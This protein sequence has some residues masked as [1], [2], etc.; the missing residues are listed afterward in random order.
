M[1]PPVA[2]N[3]ANSLCLLFASHLFCHTNF[4]TGNAVVTSSRILV[5]Q[6]FIMVSNYEYI[7][8]FRFCLHASIF[9]ELRTTG[10]LSTVPSDIGLKETIPYETTVAPGVLV[11]YHQH[12]FC[13]RID[14][15]IDG[16]T[17]SLAI[18]DSMPLI[19][20][21]LLVNNLFWRRLRS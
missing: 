16:Y 13:L 14:P 5:L 19:F 2:V 15:V 12:L 8:A 10:V 9:L 11:P 7:C 21:Y 3:N 20:E 4:R 17:N 18:E 6:T 1:E